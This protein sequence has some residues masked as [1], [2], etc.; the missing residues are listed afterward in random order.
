MASHERTRA[1]TGLPFDLPLFPLNRGGLAMWASLSTVETRVTLSLTFDLQQMI[2]IYHELER[3]NT[4]IRLH[5]SHDVRAFGRGPEEESRD[6]D[7]WFMFT[8]FQESQ[9]ERCRR[10]G[11]RCT[12]MENQDKS[13]VT[14]LDFAFQRFKKCSLTRSCLV[15]PLSQWAR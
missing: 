9:L 7:S 14:L 5:K 1:K 12:R 10:R 13:F 4:F 15:S 8:K 2:N 11:P 6:S 3:H